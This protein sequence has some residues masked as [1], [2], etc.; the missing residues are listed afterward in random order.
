MTCFMTNHPRPVT[1]R[2]LAQVYHGA[3]DVGFEPGFHS[4]VLMRKPF[5][6]GKNSFFAKIY[7]QLARSTMS[8][9]ELSEYMCVD[10]EDAK[11]IRTSLNDND[12][13]F[14]TRILHSNRS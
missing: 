4:V 11:K 8:V 7:A 12:I 6:R 1:L 13:K 9:Y 5:L 2:S 10:L 3:Q 14:Q